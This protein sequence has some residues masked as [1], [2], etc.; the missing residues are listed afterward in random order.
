MIVQAALPLVAELGAT[1]TT[2]QV[3]RAAGIGEATIFR[4]FADKETLLRACVA[5]AVRTDHLLRELGSISLDQPLEPRLIEAAE[6]LAAYL[7][8]M[9]AVV[10]P[11]VGALRSAGPPGPDG[12]AALRGAVSTADVAALRRAAGGTGGTGDGERSVPERSVPE[13]S[14][15]ERSVSERPVPERSREESFAATA[16]AVAELLEPDKDR[17]R[18]PVEQVARAFGVLVM[19][20]NRATGRSGAGAGGEPPMD[21]AGMVD[22]FLHGALAR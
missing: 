12:T 3:A 2:Q 20:L 1:V 6:A 19:S 13:R 5:E 7:D 9:G 17:F 4:A 15:S 11:L 16:Q 8:R 10:G 22:L 18:L 14:V 21:A